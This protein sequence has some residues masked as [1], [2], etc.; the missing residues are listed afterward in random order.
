M[1]LLYYSKIHFVFIVTLSCADS[2]NSGT[3]KIIMNDKTKKAANGSFICHNC[4]QH[5]CMVG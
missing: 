5:F 4:H 1:Q 3:P 2:N